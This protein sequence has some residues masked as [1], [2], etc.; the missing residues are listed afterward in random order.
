M[1]IQRH[2]NFVGAMHELRSQR[3]RRAPVQFVINGRPD[4][5]AIMKEAVRQARR[6]G[7]GVRLSWA[8]RMAIALRSVWALARQSM[9]TARLTLRTA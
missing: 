6:M 5:A 2:I 1:A 3:R 9:A 8:H 4:R 7:F